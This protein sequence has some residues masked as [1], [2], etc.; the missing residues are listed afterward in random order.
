MQLWTRNR[1]VR[2]NEKQGVVEAL[3][4]LF[5]DYFAKDVTCIDGSLLDRLNI[6][7]VIT[8]IDNTLALVDAPD[9]EPQAREWL[10]FLNR[11]GC[12]TAMISNNDPP[13][14][15]AFAKLF[16]APYAAHA[17][18]PASGA[19]LEL[20]R[21]L[22]VEPERC[23][24]VGDQMFTDIMGGNRAGMHTVLVEPLGSELDHAQFRIR[25]WS[26]KL[27]L[28]VYKRVTHGRSL[29]GQN[30]SGADVTL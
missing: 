13:R 16:D 6:Q 19:F 5:P 11:Y 26:E 20:A 1:P 27:L 30:P 18:K 21:R 23:M 28:A 7:A 17:Q 14:V 15:K 4:N 12:Q 10:D 2:E 24:V 25:R 9:P 29:S 8:D 22:G 3:F